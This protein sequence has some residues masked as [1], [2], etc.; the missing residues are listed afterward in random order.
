MCFT[1][2]S[3]CIACGVCADDCQVKAIIDGKDAYVIKPELCTDCGV[4][5]DNFFV[6]AQAAMD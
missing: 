3:V 4:C 1:I 6:E 2:S 5:L